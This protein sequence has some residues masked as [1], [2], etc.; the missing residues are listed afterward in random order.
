MGRRAL[1]VFEHFCFENY[2]KTAAHPTLQAG[3]K[4]DATHEPECSRVG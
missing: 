3:K 4:Q 2:H 1:D